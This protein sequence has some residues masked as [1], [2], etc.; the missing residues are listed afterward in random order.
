MSLYDQRVFR[1]KQSI[2]LN[3]SEN[4][5]V[6]VNEYNTLLDKVMRKDTRKTKRIIIH[7]P[8]NPKYR[9]K[10]IELSK[11][12]K[13]H[14]IEIISNFEVEQKTKESK[15]KITAKKYVDVVRQD[16]RIYNDLQIQASDLSSESE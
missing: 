4:F 11:E 12:T 15:E 14:N 13:I 5:K 10:K 2:K 9:V 7:K 6:A 8:V 16:N 3:A 1:L